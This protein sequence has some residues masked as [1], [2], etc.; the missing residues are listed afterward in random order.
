VAAADALA[1]P[2]RVVH[3]DRQLLAAARDG[4]LAICE[5]GQLVARS[6]AIEAVVEASSAIVA[7]GQ[8]ALTALEHGKHLILMNAEIDLAFGPYLLQLARDR[9]VLYSSCG[10][11]QH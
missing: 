4:V 11:D 10:G 1:C 6:D 9:G 2:S 8:H 3:D 5:D 7:G